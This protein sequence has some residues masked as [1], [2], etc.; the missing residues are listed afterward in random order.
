VTD[1][2]YANDTIKHFIS[3]AAAISSNE[4]V[5]SWK[6]HSAPSYVYWDVIDDE[7]NYLIRIGDSLL[8]QTDWIVLSSVY[9]PGTVYD[10]PVSLN[11]FSESCLTL[12]TF[13]AGGT[14]PGY[15]L[16]IVQGSDTLA[17]IKEQTGLD[18]Y[19]AR[20]LYTTFVETAETKVGLPLLLFP[21]PANESVMIAFESD[22]TD[23]VEIS[24]Y[25]LLGQLMKLQKYQALIGENTLLLELSPLPSGVYYISLKGNQSYGSAQLVI[26]N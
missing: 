10:F 11:S 22:H 12:R 19:A 14:N 16:N 23:E 15:Y 25:N 24:C 4:I 9:N 6:T 1:Q 3:P 5:V 21:N 26:R 20:N 17:S 18:R 2:E 7:G 8:I 13:T